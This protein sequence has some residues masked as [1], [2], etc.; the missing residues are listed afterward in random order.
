MIVDT[1]DVQSHLLQ[2]RAALNPWTHRPDKLENLIRSEKV[3]LGK[4]DVLVHC[5]ADDFN[6][7][8]ALLPAKKHV[9]TLPTIDRSFVSAVNS[10]PR[11]TTK[12]ICCS[13]APAMPPT[14]RLSSGFLKSSGRAS[15]TMATT[16][17]SSAILT[18]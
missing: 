1:H 14:W 12:S 10:L 6:F 3:M 18:R 4:A 11:Q 5:S 13:S 7:F 15:R 8:K 9:L 17:Q 2:E 16:S